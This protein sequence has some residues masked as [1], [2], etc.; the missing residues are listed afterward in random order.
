MNGLRSEGDAV[1]GAD[2]ARQTI[3][4]ESSLEH[5]ASGD[6]LSGEK[7][8]TGEQESRV[9]VCDGEGVAVDPVAGFKL[10][11]EVGGPEIV[12]SFGRGSDNSR[13]L[14]WTAASSFHDQSAASQEI[15]SRA[16]SWPVSDAWISGLEHAEELS[17]S[18]E[19]MLSPEVAYEL[20]E[21][22]LYS[23]RAVVRSSASVPEPTS[24]FLF[25][26]REPLVAD[27]AT[28]AVARA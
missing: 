27:S 14:M 20:A 8:V 25:V 3:L 18:P 10:S 2:R 17:C 21:L 22:A 13:V 28:D 23:M 11:L 9:L 12:R 5:W 1:V 7:P 19:G 15:G 26:S 4:P 6:C 24:A 16:R